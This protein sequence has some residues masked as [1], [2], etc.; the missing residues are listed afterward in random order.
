MNELTVHLTQS[1]REIAKQVMRR[2]AIR[3]DKAMKAMAIGG[4]SVL[5]SVVQQAILDTDEMESLR[6]G[7]LQGQ[8]GLYPSLATNVPQ[9][10]AEAVA[11]S[12]ELIARKTFVKGSVGLQGGL[13]ISIQPTDF[14]NI[15][16]MPDSSIKYYSKRYNRIVTLDW[17]DWLLKRGQEIIVSDYIVEYGGHGRSGQ[18]KMKR[19]TGSVWR[20]DSAYSGT[21]DDN[22]ISRALNDPSVRNN[23][24]KVLNQLMNQYFSGN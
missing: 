1:N 11:D 22:F 15:A 21:V 17:L 8:L 7:K 6:G 18:A 3:A 13:S 5:K 20:V 19:S 10:I 24:L 16:N 14:S 2:I 12:I 9:D 4:R 23:M